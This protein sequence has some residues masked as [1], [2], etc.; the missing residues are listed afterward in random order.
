MLMLLPGF[1]VGRPCRRLYL[2]STCDVQ[3]SRADRDVLLPPS[4]GVQKAIRC[5]AA[6]TFPAG[7]LTQ[8]TALPRVLKSFSS[9]VARGP[10]A[11]M[12]CND[13]LRLSLDSKLAACRLSCASAF[14]PISTTFPMKYK[15]KSVTIVDSYSTE[16]NI[17]RK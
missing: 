8:P 5:P 3:S 1:A 2:L 12:A 4:F 6:N 16:I 14:Y 9:N 11:F 13:I 15:M 10:S 7:L 17:C